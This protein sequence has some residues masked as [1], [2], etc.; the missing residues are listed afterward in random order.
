MQE[1]GRLEL[2]GLQSS[3]ALRGRVQ[4][5]HRKHSPKRTYAA[6]YIP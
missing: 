4:Y 5:P 2:L 6:V 3:S 1:S